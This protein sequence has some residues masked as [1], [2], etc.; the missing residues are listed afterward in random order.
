MKTKLRC[1]C[2]AGKYRYINSHMQNVIGMFSDNKIAISLCH[3]V[4]KL[5]KLQRK[6]LVGLICCN[7]SSPPPTERRF[8]SVQSG[9]FPRRSRHSFFVFIIF[10]KWP[11]LRFTVFVAVCHGANFGNFSDKIGSFFSEKSKIILN[12]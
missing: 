11:L 12:S 1:G 9:R 4:F 6:L 10:T 8:S 7:G 5:Q 2:H 3:E